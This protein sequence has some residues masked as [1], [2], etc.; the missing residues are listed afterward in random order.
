M[1]SIRVELEARER[2]V[3]A[4]EAD[5]ELGAFFEEL[6]QSSHERTHMTVSANHREINKIINICE[7]QLC[8]IN[9]NRL[10]K[11]REK[12]DSILLL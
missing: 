3:K 9:L 6:R 8:E 1:E 5:E 2:R 7:F 11:I 4:K 10:P 12:I